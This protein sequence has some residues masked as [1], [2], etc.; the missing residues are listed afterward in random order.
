LFQS[1]SRERHFQ[2]TIPRR[3]SHRGQGQL[4]AKPEDKKDDDSGLWSRY[5]GSSSSS[6]NKKDKNDSSGKSKSSSSSGKK[7]NDSDPSFLQG[8]MGRFRKDDEAERERA[9]AEKLAKERGLFDTTY[10]TGAF[11]KLDG[12]MGKFRQDLNKGRAADEDKKVQEQRRR[13]EDA[14]RRRKKLQMEAKSLADQK[15]A[16]QKRQKAKEQQAEETRKLEEQM[17]KRTQ[18]LEE[19]KQRFQAAQK[20]DQERKLVALKQQEDQM[21]KLVGD[22]RKKELAAR[23]RRLRDEAIRKAA[24]QTATTKRQLAV[25]QPSTESSVFSSLPSLSSFSFSS[26]KDQENEK[27]R[28]GGEGSLMNQF[29][30]ALGSMLEFNK[31]DE[32]WIAVAPKWAIAPGQIVPITSAGLDLLLVAS[33]DGSSLHCVANSCPHF[34][35]PLETGTLDRRPLEIPD[36]P[37]Y[38]SS[39][40]TSAER[41]VEISEET[42]VASLLAQDGCEDCIVC[43]LHRTAFALASGEVRGEWCPYP[44]VLG[45]MMGAVKQKTPLPVFD[46][47]TRGKNIEVRI[48]SPLPTKGEKK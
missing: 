38:S 19:E 2:R 3:H 26:R 47:R 37:T 24:K 8:F 15:E 36:L 4:S 48:N 10:L 42:V 18:Q 29:Q 46:V 27:K 6:D 1:P 20:A 12:E 16:E 21:R 14:E 34:G 22:R 28:E 9:L 45:N 43:P 23:E 13:Q 25:P 44:P 32:E 39:S 5:F 17:R 35:T 40:S 11:E 33:K 41:P 30:K 7:G 31:K